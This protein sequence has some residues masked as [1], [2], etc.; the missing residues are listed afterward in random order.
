MKIVIPGGAGFVGRNLVRIMVEDGYDPNNIVVIDSDEKKL[1]KLEKLNINVHLADLAEDGE[2]MR[3]FKGADYVVNLAAQI[4]SPDYEPFYR[5]NILATK[6]VLEACEQAGVKRIVHFSSIAVLSVRKDHYAQTK[7]EG[8]ELVKSCGLEYCVLR[9]SIMY[10]PTNEENLGYLI[11]FSRKF[12]IFPIPGHGKWP[13]QPIYIDDVCNLVLSIMRD[14][15][16]NEV[17][18]VNGKDIVYFKDMVKDVQKQMGGLKFQVHLPVSL[19]KFLMIGF[20]KLTGNAHFTEDQVDSLTAE[21]IFPEYP[22]WEEFDI[23]VTSFEDGVRKM[24][25]FES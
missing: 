21:E 16:S 9:P 23:E 22:W 11:D 12:P 7:L 4:S 17:Y 8:E 2:W 19:F 10:G 14:F 18:N 24:M 25:A 6:K 3:E 13:R 5:N 1:R 20:Q 15:P